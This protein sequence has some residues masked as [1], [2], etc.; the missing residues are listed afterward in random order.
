[1]SHKVNIINWELLLFDTLD[2]FHILNGLNK[3]SYNLWKSKAWEHCDHL[4]LD[5]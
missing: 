4:L 3:L 5:M 1:M 2:V